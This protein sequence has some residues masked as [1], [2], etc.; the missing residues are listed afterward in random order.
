MPFAA[1]SVHHIR[2]AIDHI[3]CK[4]IGTSSE[5]A[6]DNKTNDI[7]DSASSLDCEPFS[8]TV[9]SIYMMPK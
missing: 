3:D 6:S 1:I 5:Y 4:I 2:H 7:S 9:F 8:R